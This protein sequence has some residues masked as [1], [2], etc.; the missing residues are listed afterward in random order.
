MLSSDDNTT[1]FRFPWSATSAGALTL[2]RSAYGPKNFYHRLTRRRIPRL[3]RCWE[4][5]CWFVVKFPLVSQH[6]LSLDEFLYRKPLFRTHPTTVHLSTR[7]FCFL[8]VPVV[9][10]WCLIY[11]YL[12]CCSST[13]LVGCR[14]QSCYAAG[15]KMCTPVPYLPWFVVFVIA[16][17]CCG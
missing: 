3:T 7:L 2:L 9:F 12:S 14:G 15:G 6:R 4:V 5:Q 13:R 1:F 8:G 10:S 16:V 17:L 11:P